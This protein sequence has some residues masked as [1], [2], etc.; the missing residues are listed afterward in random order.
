KS[1]MHLQ[2]PSTSPFYKGFRQHQTLMFGFKLNQFFRLGRLELL[3]VGAPFGEIAGQLFERLPAC[4][5]ER[6]WPV[7]FIAKL[8][9]R[10]YER[11]IK[12]QWQFSK[13]G[14]PA[15]SGFKEGSDGGPMLAMSP[16]HALASVV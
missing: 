5:G 9:H 4:S 7:G 11:L 8:L 10:I 3:Q 16:R 14:S 6:I 15:G 13:I 2:I 1:R 12:R